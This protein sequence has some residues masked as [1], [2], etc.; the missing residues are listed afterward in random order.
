[1]QEVQEGQRHLPSPWHHW[2][3]YGH[4]TCERRAVAVLTVRF[5]G[6]SGPDAAAGSLG[7]GAFSA[8]LLAMLIVFVF[9]PI[10]MG[11]GG[12]GGDGVLTRHPH[13][14]R[15]ME[16]LALVRDGVAVAQGSASGT[17]EP[18]D[19]AGDS[20]AGGEASWPSPK[21][22]AKQTKE[23]KEKKEKQQERRER[24]EQQGRADDGGNRASGKQSTGAVGTERQAAATATDAAAAGGGSPKSTAAGGSERWV[25]V[26]M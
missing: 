25:H 26:S 1:M 6:S 2:S 14:Q 18:L 16:L 23:L 24:V 3:P 10:A 20:S 15:W 8:L 12:R 22:K 17:Y 11:G 7:G 9:V 19:R 5:R 13:H 21:K 4:Q